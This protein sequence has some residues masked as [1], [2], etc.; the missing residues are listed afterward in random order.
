MGNVRRKKSKIVIR[1]GAKVYNLQKEQWVTLNQDI[2]I[3]E[4][5][6]HIGHL[7]F[8]LNNERYSFVTKGKEAK[9]FYEIIYS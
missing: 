8:G 4:W 5:V 1:K 3:S 7:R 9:K 2:N 6:D